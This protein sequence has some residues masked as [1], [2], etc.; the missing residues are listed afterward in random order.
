[1]ASTTI[2]RLTDYVFN[3]PEDPLRS[4]DC[5]K[6]R[7]EMIKRNLAILAE[8]KDKSCNLF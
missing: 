1:M 7:C 5:V 4:V 2:E 8:E 3:T 6:Q